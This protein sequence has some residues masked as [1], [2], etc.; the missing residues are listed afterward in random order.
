MRAVHGTVAD[1]V[2]GA[3]DAV[4]RVPPAVVEWV[5]DEPGALVSELVVLAEPGP[6]GEVPALVTAVDAS[7]VRREDG[8]TER[9]ARDLR[10]RR[11]VLTVRD[12]VLGLEAAA[13]AAEDKAQ[14]RGRRIRDLRDELEEA[15]AEVDRLRAR[16][17]G[18]EGSEEPEESSVVGRAT[19]RLRSR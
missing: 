14:Q 9:A 7:V 4:R 11:E 2:A 10:E 12:H 8:F 16:L 5:R 6:P 13:S 3:A 15:R 1:P 18:A 17:G 19:R